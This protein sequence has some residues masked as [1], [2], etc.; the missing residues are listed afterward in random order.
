MTTSTNDYVEMDGPTTLAPSPPETRWLLSSHGRPNWPDPLPLLM[1]VWGASH[2]FTLDIERI[3]DEA[4]ASILV[5]A[6]R[7]DRRKR[8]GMN[9]ADAMIAPGSD[10]A[11]LP[12]GAILERVE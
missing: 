2:T 11:A 5:A 6:C 3:D 9:E 12:I 7:A 8:I 1:S 4:L 10:A